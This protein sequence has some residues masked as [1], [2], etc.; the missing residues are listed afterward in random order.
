MLERGPGRSQHASTH[1]PTLTDSRESR[2]RRHASLSL[3]SQRARGQASATT[4]SAEHTAQA[5]S[6]TT[7]PAT[8]AM[9]QQRQGRR[10][11]E[12]WRKGGGEGSNARA[13]VARGPMCCGGRGG[14]REGGLAAARW[15]T[16]TLAA[17]A[18]AAAETLVAASAGG[19]AGGGRGHPRTPTRTCT[20]VHVHVHMR[21]ACSK[22]QQQAVSRSSSSS[23][24]Q[25]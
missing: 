22:Q 23:A 11:R 13:S 14:E 18:R 5:P 4:L 6:A 7:R 17:R 9:G 2:D 20:H 12:S 21:S 10:R 19:D 3:S 25:R 1:A 16:E 15:T 8:L 24:K